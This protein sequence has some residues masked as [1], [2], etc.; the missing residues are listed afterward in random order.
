MRVAGA[1]AARAAAVR[2]DD[3]PSRLARQDHIAFKALLADG[4]AAGLQFCVEGVHVADASTGSAFLQAS[5]LTQVKRGWV[6]F[7]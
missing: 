2:K 6:H 5:A 1:E 4:H 7:L 3:K